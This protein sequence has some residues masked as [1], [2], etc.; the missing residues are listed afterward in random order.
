M[1]N[2]TN[3]PTKDDLIRSFADRQKIKMTLAHGTKVIDI[4][5][6]Q[7]QH[8][9]GSGYSFNFV[10]TTGA[11]GYYDTRKKQGYINPPQKK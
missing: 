3:G 10:A 11:R 6:N 2:I 8:E 9:D 7:L 1:I 4:V 5:I